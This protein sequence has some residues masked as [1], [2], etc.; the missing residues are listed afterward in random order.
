[1]L[2]NQEYLNQVA[3][4]LKRE[5]IEPHLQRQILGTVNELLKHYSVSFVRELLPTL[6]KV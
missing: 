2:K 3:E 6:F 1:M 5:N 4:L